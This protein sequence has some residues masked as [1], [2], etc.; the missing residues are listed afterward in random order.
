MMQHIR[1][2]YVITLLPTL[3]ITHS[4]EILHFD[5]HENFINLR[6]TPKITY[7]FVREDNFS[8]KNS[9]IEIG[10]KEIIVMLSN[11]I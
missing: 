9:R 11:E 5:I 4:N 3:S 7:L 1:Y 6:R 10:D 2:Q 8:L